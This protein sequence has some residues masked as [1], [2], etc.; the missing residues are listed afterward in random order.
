VNVGG[1]QLDQVIDR[2]DQVRLELFRLRA[3]LVPVEELTPEEREELELS[4]EEVRR[5]KCVDLDEI[6]GESG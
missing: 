6:L 1:Q 4:R 5:G 3:L 2:L